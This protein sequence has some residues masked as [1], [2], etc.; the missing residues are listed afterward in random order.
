[1]PADPEMRSGGM[2]QIAS[3]QLRARDAGP[4]NVYFEQELAAA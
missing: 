3:V 4:M 1:L 2:S